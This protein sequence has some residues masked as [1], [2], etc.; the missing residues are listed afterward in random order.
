MKNFFEQLKTR[1]KL[2]ED[3][4]KII[5][6][7]IESLKIHKDFHALLMPA[8]YGR[9]V[10]ILKSMGVPCNQMFAIEQEGDRHDEIVSCNREDRKEYNGIVTTP[11]A[12]GAKEAI[13]WAYTFRQGKPFDFI[14]LDFYGRCRFNY[15]Y[16]IIKRILKLKMLAPNG[17]MILT[18]SDETRCTSEVLEQNDKLGEIFSGRHLSEIFLLEA[19]KEV[20]CQYPR[21]NT[22][23]YVSKGSRQIPINYYTTI[24]DWREPNSLQ[25]WSDLTSS[26]L[27]EVVG[28][29]GNDKIDLDD[30]Y[31]SPKYKIFQEKMIADI[32]E[33]LKRKKSCSIELFCGGG[34]T[35]IA[36]NVAMD[37]KKVLMVSPNVMAFEGFNRDLK[38]AA[39]K[40]G[41]EIEINYENGIKICDLNIITP[42]K[43]YNE[44]KKEC[45]YLKPFE[46]FMREVDLVILDEVHRYPEDPE[47]TLQVISKVKEI[48]EQFVPNSHV[49]TMSGT[50]F[51]SD[52]KNPYGIKDPDIKHSLCDLITE[53]CAPE[54]FGYTV[55]IQVDGI[56]KVSRSSGMVKFKTRY[57]ERYHNEISDIISRVYGMDPTAS[58]CIFVSHVENA[59]L[60]RDAINSKLGKKFEVLDHKTP[61]NVRQE[62]IAEIN[63]G[64]LLG[65]ITVQ[66]G[67]ESLNIPRLKYCH[68]VARIIS[69]VKLMQCI[70]RVARSHKD[71]N[72]CVV[73]DYQV[74]KDK[75]KKLANGI[76]TIN[77][78]RRVGNG[79]NK[80]LSKNISFGGRIFSGEPISLSLGTYEGWIL[81][82]QY[83]R[84]NLNWIVKYNELVKWLKKYNKYPS[85]RST[86]KQERLLYVWYNMQKC[87]KR[88]KYCYLLTLEQIKMMEQLPGWK[89][90][91]DREER[92][93][94]NYNKVLDF[95]ENY[96][97]YP[98]IGS[99]NKEEQKLYRWCNQQKRSKKGVGSYLLTPERV[100]MLEQ[101][102]GW[103]WV[104]N[105]DEEWEIHYNKLLI[106]LKSHNNKYPSK[107]LGDIEE[108]KLSKW[109]NT[110]KRSKRGQGECLMTPKR[111][112]MLEQLPG[113]KWNN[114]WDEQWM[115][116]YDE[117]SSFLKN[118]DRYPSQYSKNQEERRLSTW[119]N[120]QRQKKRKG[121]LSSEYNELLE[122][123]P[124]W[125]CQS[126]KKRAN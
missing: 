82:E 84:S 3:K 47:N 70:G 102:P 37:Y 116:H 21:L 22:E 69:D 107:K 100:K 113:W 98:S 8:L 40:F 92:W 1:D 39:K 73:I 52:G 93:I 17:V 125:Q 89:W 78:I 10:R 77:D 6:R 81:S 90:V 31:L 112:M 103:K 65:Y 11:K 25:E 120:N 35:F 55:P 43:L 2:C 86:N 64:E 56:T 62:I 18:F 51:R 123:F 121:C 91:D 72:C 27:Y 79:N 85:Y 75:I 15:H 57:L 13:E 114:D 61:N 119:Y 126:H 115:V 29:K 23:K 63:K 42:F 87:A 9:E 46:M 108:Q 88:G 28:Y 50:H 74:M 16:E 60:L 95:L 66:V 44:W 118:Y 34:K 76:K 20:K 106:F 111:A 30:Y 58:H 99:K 19:V 48:I 12:M 33:E 97:K 96:N 24:A 105:I 110:Q 83:K 117:Y 45:S 36:G 26:L 49:L 54:M 109:V 4:D 94:N 41:R 14:Y 59:K 124:E 67:S 104:H 68:L 7:V 80:P 38:V 71:K 5:I 32:K 122:K 53:N 101:L